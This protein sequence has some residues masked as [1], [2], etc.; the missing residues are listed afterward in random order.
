M[1]CRP[2]I[3]SVLEIAESWRSA[4]EW[5]LQHQ[6]PPRWNQPILSVT[7]ETVPGVN[8]AGFKQVYSW[9]GSVQFDFEFGRLSYIMLK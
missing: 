7:I 6:C 1:N 8:V 5:H 4:Q 2:L 3:C 9:D